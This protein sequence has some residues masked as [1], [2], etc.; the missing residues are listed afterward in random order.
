MCFEPVCAAGA[1][2]GEVLRGRRGFE[3]KQGYPSPPRYDPSIK[4]AYLNGLGTKVLLPG[5]VT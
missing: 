5:G 3:V 4:V 1:Y 2:C